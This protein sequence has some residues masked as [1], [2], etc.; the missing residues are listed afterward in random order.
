VSG[1]FHFELFFGEQQL[2]P[3]S[4][5]I[6]LESDSRLVGVWLIDLMIGITEVSMS[7]RR[8][9]KSISRNLEF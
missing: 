6:F 4:F 2:F 5:F 3:G 7:G 1:N 8:L 9:D